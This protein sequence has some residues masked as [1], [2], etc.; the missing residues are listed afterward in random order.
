MQK[1]SLKKILIVIQRT[2]DSMDERMVGHGEEVAYIMYKLLKASNDYSENEILRLMELAMFHD[3]GV[4]KV[5]KRDKILDIDS[6]E[7]IEHSVYGSL[8]IKHFSPLADLS[9]VVLGHHLFPNDLDNEKKKIIP[10]EAL[11]LHL[12]DYI[13]IRKMNGDKMDKDS[14]MKTFG[15]KVLPEHKKLF[16]IACTEYNLLE[17]ILDKNYLEELYEIFDKIILSREE[18]IS[19]TRMLTYAIDFRSESTVIHSIA[20]EEISAQIANMLNIDE[21]MTRKI[22]IASM[23]HDIGKIVVPIE[24][25]EKPGKLTEDEYKQIQNHAIIGYKILSGLGI[26]DIR[27]IATLH[28]EKL[29]GTGYPFGLKGDEISLEVRIVAI[30][31]VVS[32]LVNIRSYK[33]EFPKEKVIS[34]LSNMA[35]SNK[36]DNRICNLVINNYDYIIDKVR[37]NT[38]KMLSVYNNLIEEYEL[39]LK[40]FKRAA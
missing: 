29:D 22:K 25:L 28:H 6:E 35:S 9:Q 21:K 27:D 38:K 32:A 40:Y 39:L 12:A 14:I 8:F 18:V 17:N 7:P 31:D 2:L 24:I 13:S 1:V 11:L 15:D 20:V 10:K 5:E 36:I 33:G 30:A 34:I 4:Y 19:Y 3:I 16:E 26:D 37:E 23:L